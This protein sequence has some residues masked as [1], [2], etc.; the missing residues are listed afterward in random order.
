M[1]T[2]NV[3]RNL[4]APQIRDGEYEESIM[5]NF[6][7]GQSVLRIRADDAD[8]KVREAES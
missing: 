6:N 1:L 4:N 5:E 2:V 3:L 7:I 8:N